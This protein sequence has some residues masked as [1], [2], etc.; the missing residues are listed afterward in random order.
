MDKKKILYLSLILIGLVR[1]YYMYKKKFPSVPTIAVIQMASH[2]S[3]D[4]ARDTFCEVIKSELGEENINITFYNC[5]GSINT[6]ENIVPQLVHDR[7]IKLF[8]TLGSLPTQSIYRAEYER[9]ILFAAVSD[10]YVIGIRQGK[11]NISGLSD[12]T[13][14]TLPLVM[15]DKILPGKKKVGLLYSYLNLNKNELM[16][17]KKNLEAGGKIVIDIVVQN[18][19]ELNSVLEQYLD[20]IDVLVSLC[21]NI[22]AYASRAVI[23]LANE[24]NVPF[25]ATFTAPLQEGALAVT[26]TSYSD[27]GREIAARAISILR[28]EKRPCDFMITMQDDQTIYVSR[29]VAKRFNLIIADLEDQGNFVLI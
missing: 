21:D 20:D 24:Y 18:E 25:I 7:N 17:V 12:M 1:I 26:G 6:L 2:V 22:V 14:P 9:P 15:I 4:A 28:G 10:P 23:R 8:Y 5:H 27:C 19:F 3:L 11:S 13:I 29:E 16:Q